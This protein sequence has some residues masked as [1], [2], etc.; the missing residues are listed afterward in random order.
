MLFCEVKNCLLSYSF[1]ERFVNYFITAIANLMIL[2][3]AADVNYF[4]LAAKLFV[5]IHTFCS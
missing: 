4:R 2:C 5:P 1:A 3:F